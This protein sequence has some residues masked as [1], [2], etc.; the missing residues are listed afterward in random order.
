M[1]RTEV[2]NVYNYFR[3]ENLCQKCT[4]FV[5]DKPLV[6]P[7][8]AAAIAS[9][10]SDPIAGLGLIALSLGRVGTRTCSRGGTAAPSDKCV[11]PNEYTPKE[12]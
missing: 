5:L 7:E 4:L 12:D 6:S 9:T 8:T 11:R 1:T 10:L 2:P 3:D